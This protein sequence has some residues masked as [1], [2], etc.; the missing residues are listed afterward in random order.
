[1]KCSKVL[2]KNQFRKISAQPVKGPIRDHYIKAVSPLVSLIGADSH[3]II[4]CHVI[5]AV[6][7]QVQSFAF[8]EIC[9]ITCEYYR[10]V[11]II[12]A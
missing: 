5:D 8:G 7:K 3:A 10:Y 4:F 11:S 2:Y 12:S 1:M 6:R 9:T